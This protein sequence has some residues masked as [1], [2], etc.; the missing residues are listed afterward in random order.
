[1]IKKGEEFTVEENQRKPE[2]K[3]W[4]YAL[5]G[6]GAFL[7]LFLLKSLT[8]PRLASFVTND[9][10]NQLF[11]GFATLGIILIYNSLIHTFTFYDSDSFAVFKKRKVEEVRFTEELGVIIRSKEFWLE[12]LPAVALSVLFSL[13]GGFYETVYTVF[14]IGSAPEWAFRALPL[15]SI[16][17]LLFLVSLLCR[18]EIHRYW[19]ELIHK[20][21][22][23][24]IDNKAKFLLKMVVILAMYP[25]LYPYAPYVIFLVVSF[26]G[27][28]GAL[29]S[30]LSVLGFVAAVAG[31]IL[32]ILGLMKW[33]THRLRKA[34]LRSLT[35]TAEAKGESLEI[36][37]KEQ[38][39]VRGYDLTLT[40]GG[41]SYA[42]RIINCL[43]RYTPLFFTASDAYFL[44]RIG[45]KE[46]HTSI[47]KHFEYSF[48]TDDKKLIVLIK[49]PRKLFASECGATRKLFSGDKIWNYIIFDQRSF[50]GAQ[51]RE[52]LHRSNEENR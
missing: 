15:V 33:K 44:H 23:N 38:R 26:F 11:Y 19:F 3:N 28:V 9:I 25:I 47:E 30:V 14:F 49:F 7:L 24:R 40:S 35:A 51:D 18:Y 43:N 2:K 29:I 41:K 21:E 12:T 31:V 46:H 16:P 17:L 36:Y 27:I 50:L 39:A 52:C 10:P 6:C 48:A 4:Q 37:T 32:G 45:T 20:G 5:R 42:V 1:M 8:T 22:E 13:F 34:F